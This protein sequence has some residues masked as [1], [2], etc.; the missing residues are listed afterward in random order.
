VLIDVND[1]AQGHTTKQ[2]WNAPD[3][4]IWSEKPVHEPLIDEEAFK[5]AQALLG[6]KGSA[7]ERSLLRT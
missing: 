5:Q 3:K 7:D 4:W 1:V 2:T 6:A